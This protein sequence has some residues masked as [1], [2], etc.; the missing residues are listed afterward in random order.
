MNDP[1]KALRTMIEEKRFRLARFNAS[2]PEIDTSKRWEDIN[3]MDALISALENATRM[4]PLSVI[5][6]INKGIIQASAHEFKPNCVQVWIPLSGNVSL[7][8]ARPCIIDLCDFEYTENGIEVRPMDAHDYNHIGFRSGKLY[9]S[10]KEME[11][12]N[13]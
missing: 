3:T 6:R 2:K 1:I 13:G 7:D 8:N 10:L 12:N 9:K 4:I 5:D 11:V